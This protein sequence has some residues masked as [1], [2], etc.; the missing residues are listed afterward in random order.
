MVITIFLF[1][2]AAFASYQSPAAYHTKKIISTY[3]INNDYGYFQDILWDGKKYV[4]LGMTDSV[5]YPQI[6]TSKDGV[7]WKQQAYNV[8]GL[9]KLLFNGKNYMAIGDLTPVGATGVIHYR[10]KD[11]NE[12]TNKGDTRNIVNIGDRLVQANVISSDNGADWQI[13]SGQKK[14]YGTSWVPDKATFVYG[15]KFGFIMSNKVFFSTDGKEFTKGQNIVVRDPNKLTPKNYRYLGNESYLSPNEVVYDGKAFYAVSIDYYGFTILKS[16]DAINWNI[17]YFDS[18]KNTHYTKIL[19]QNGKYIILRE[20]QIMRSHNGLNWT[21]EKF[22]KT[23]LLNTEAHWGHIIPPK[24]VYYN[25]YYYMK[26]TDY[27][28]EPT[29][30]SIYITKDFKTYHEIQIE[31]LRGDLLYVDDQFIF[32]SEGVYDHLPVGITGAIKVLVEND[33][34]RFNQPPVIKES[35]TLVPLRGIF[36]ALGAV[37]QWDQKTK[38][39]TATKE[40]LTIK[41]TINSKI[42]YIGEKETEISQPSEIINGSTMVPLRF[43]SEALGAKVDWDSRSYIISITQ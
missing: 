37:V 7:Q 5:I 27:D 19:L 30:R 20:G 36:E 14:G 39:V 26:K 10:D 31:D 32:T 35:R 43:I 34:L 2:S 21:I 16:I 22:N 28:N 9:S 6:Y 33:Y 15:N 1:Q 38:T 23:E 40:D 42:A 3:E 4:G 13:I 12:L 25:G 17:V 24:V 8:W 41:L 18:N 11:G 29:V